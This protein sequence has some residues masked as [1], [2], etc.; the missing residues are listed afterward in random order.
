MEVP[1]GLFGSADWGFA[2][3]GSGLVLFFLLSFSMISR[4]FCSIVL[5]GG[6]G[7]SSL[8]FWRRGW[9]GLFPVAA[10]LWFALDW[11]FFYKSIKFPN[12]SGN[13]DK[14]DQMLE[15]N[16][17]LFVP[18]S[19]ASKFTLKKLICRNHSKK[20][21]QARADCC[22]TDFLVRLER[23]WSYQLLFLNST[24]SWHRECADFSLF[25]ISLSL[26]FKHRK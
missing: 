2:L 5:M 15:A 26:P 9:L 8:A 20:N 1:W 21:L 11:A 18:F 23:H 6:F 16:K 3:G 10:V 22:F 7:L 19:H 4:F 12:R 14:L 24:S 17:R 25:L 13:F